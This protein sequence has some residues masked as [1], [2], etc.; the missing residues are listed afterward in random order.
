MK[1][2]YIALIG[3]L[4]TLSVSAQN[5]FDVLRYSTLDYYGG[6]RFNAM[7]GSFGALGADM[8][9]L[10]INPGGIGVY[11]SSDF[12]FTPGFHFSTTQ[13]KTDSVK[14][15]DDQYDF[16]FSHVGFVGSFP[17]ESGDWKF[18]NIGIG[19]N[20]TA[21]YNSSSFIKSNTD[22]SYLNTYTNDLNAGNGTLEEDIPYD[23]PFGA[24]LAYQNY[25]VN[26]IFGDSTQYNQ[27]FKD[28]KNITQITT[29]NT[30][31]GSG[32]MYFS[33]GGNYNDK[34]YVGIL[35]GIPSVRY[36]YERT[37]KE[38]SALADTLTDFK[39]FTV[40]DNVN[41]SGSGVN[42][43]LGFILKMLPWLRIGAAFHTPTK[44]FLTD[45]YETSI[46]SERKDRTMWTETSPYGS[47]D[48][49]VTT[50]YRVVTSAS[51]VFGKYGVINADYELVDYSTG[52]IQEDR[53]FESS[54]ADF[55][56]ENRNIK[57][58]FV[59]AHNLR[60]GTEWRLDPFRIRGG[61]RHIGNSLSEEF[62]ADNSAFIYSGG[63]GIKQ[64]AYYIDLAYLV[65]DYQTEDI[66]IQEQQQFSTV[67]HLDHFVT[68]TVGF[69]F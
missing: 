29:Y 55:I 66:V 7:G 49:S 27:V 31:G 20:R 11:K 63:I 58:N 18:F 36:D 47:F 61:I 41:T 34:L 3:V 30:G 4:M 50:P 43:K 60:L 35:L 52:G 22:S 32:E 42:F 44:Y 46:T 33:M 5:E 12:S 8:G 14:F 15:N 40:R 48:Y 2:L 37:Y 45:T 62:K 23:Y 24:N 26:P 28:S 6:A 57:N 56:T 13:S 19:Y 64:E 17:S 10:S 39:S 68:F 38:T 53:N 21:N 25:L 51:L 67:N 65:K 54:G 59:V 16:N 1:N 69:R 9:G